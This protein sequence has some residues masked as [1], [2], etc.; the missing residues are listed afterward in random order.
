MRTQNKTITG[1]LNRNSWVRYNGDGSMSFLVAV[2]PDGKSTELVIGKRFQKA[3]DQAI[4]L[5][6]GFKKND[7]VRI[8]YYTCFVN[9]PNKYRTKSTFHNIVDIEH[10]T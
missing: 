7:H 6:N 5:S 8:T 9:R 4:S 1:A 10:I 2:T 3:K